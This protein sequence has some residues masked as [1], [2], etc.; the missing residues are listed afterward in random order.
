MQLYRPK[1]S[2][3]FLQDSLK[4]LIFFETSSSVA[5]VVTAIRC[6]ACRQQQRSS[7]RAPPPPH[8]TTTPPRPGPPRPRAGNLGRRAGFNKRLP[9]DCEREFSS[10][11]HPLGIP[12]PPTWVRERKLVRVY[13]CHSFRG[14]GAPWTAEARTRV[15]VTRHQHDIARGLVWVCVCAQLCAR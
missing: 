4:I 5:A 14:S 7:T 3:I 12:H 15:H 8:G 2:I 11:R 6:S 13:R 9:V 1:Y 10:S